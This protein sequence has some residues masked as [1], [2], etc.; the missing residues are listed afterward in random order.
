MLCQGALHRLNVISQLFSELARRQSLSNLGKHR[1]KINIARPIPL[2]STL[3]RLP[4]V[5]QI[6]TK[7]HCDCRCDSKVCHPRGV[8]GEIG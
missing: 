1:E 4:K 5:P 8:G 2:A 7:G 6:L 3:L